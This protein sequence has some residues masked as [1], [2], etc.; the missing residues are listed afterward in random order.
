MSG[1][2]IILILEFDLK[3]I[4][5]YKAHDSFMIITPSLNFLRE[6]QR[7]SLVMALEADSLKW[8]FT[9]LKN[10]EMKPLVEVV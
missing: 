3:L 4:H 9:T 2:R 1:R 5:V 8:H 7:A 10:H 6:T